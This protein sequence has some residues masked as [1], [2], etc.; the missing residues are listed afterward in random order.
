MADMIMNVE[1]IDKLAKQIES[2]RISALTKMKRLQQNVNSISLS[3]WS[4]TQRDTFIK[5]FNDVC[6]RVEK[7]LNPDNGPFADM[8][9][10]LRK[11]KEM[12]MEF[13]QKNM[14]RSL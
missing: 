11:M 1:E 8:A 9:A 3:S 12:G 7:G 13:E 4:G 2:A 10:Y 5:N 6:F 14:G